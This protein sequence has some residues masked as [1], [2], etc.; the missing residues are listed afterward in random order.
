[1]KID[2]MCGHRLLI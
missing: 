2:H 1:M